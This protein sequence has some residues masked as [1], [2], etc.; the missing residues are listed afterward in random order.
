[1]KKP[2][3]ACPVLWAFGTSI[4]DVA[5]LDD[6]KSESLLTWALEYTLDCDSVERERAA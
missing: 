3:G 2:I 5:L 6:A 1:M 4:N